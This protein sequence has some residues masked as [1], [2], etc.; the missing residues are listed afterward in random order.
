MPVPATMACIEI[1]SFGAPDVLKPA[2]RPT[3]KPAAG[4][5]LVKVAAAGVNRPDVLQRYGKYPPPPGA[6]DLPG[7][8]IAGTVAAVG[9]GVTEFKPGDAVCALIS[10]GGYAEYCTAPVPQ[11]LPVPKRLSMVE[12]AAVPETFFTV[13]T[14]VFERGRLKAGETFLVHGGASGIGTTAIQLAKAF[15]ARVLATAGTPEKCE[16]CRS[17]GADRAIN[18]KSEDFVAIAKEATGGQGVDLTLDMV[19]GDYVGKNIDIAKVEGRIVQI[20]FLRS[21]KTE[22]NLAPLMIKRLTLTGS[23]LRARS[24]AEKGA[25]AAAVREHVWPLLESGK[26]KP[27]IHATFPLADAAGAHRLMEADTHIGKIVLTVAG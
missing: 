14:N 25:V 21:P 8:E 19:G 3:P 1:S 18:Y 7:L 23:T 27:R 2:T 26:V 5:V 22:V 13:W 20:A 24:V 4:E 10:G 12:A 11:C 16:A 6:S 9:P 17:L 15:G